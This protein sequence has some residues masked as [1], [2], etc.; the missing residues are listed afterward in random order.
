VRR[1]QARLAGATKLIS[2]NIDALLYDLLGFS[3]EW[4]TH[5]LGARGAARLQPADLIHQDAVDVDGGSSRGGG[6]GGGGGGGDTGV[7][8][9]VCQILPLPICRCR[10]K[11]QSNWVGFN[12]P[13]FFALKFNKIIGHR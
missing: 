9:V 2:T 3:G 1:L 10:F 6:G 4:A 7:V 8:L 12:K 5:H 13:S 11:F